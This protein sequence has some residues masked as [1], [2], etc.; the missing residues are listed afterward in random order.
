[1][2]F[3]EGLGY[4]L[5]MVLFIGPVF[6]TLL[7]GALQHGASGGVMVALGIITSDLIIAVI[8]ISGLVHLIERWLTGPWMALAGAVLLFALGLRYILRPKLD[9]DGPQR[10]KRRKAAGLF[11]RGFLVN[12]VNPFVFAIWI[13]LIVHATNTYGAGQGVWMFTTGVLL[14]IFLTDVGKALLAPRLHR[15]LSVNRLKKV[16]TVIGVFMIL[17]AVR[18]LFHAFANWD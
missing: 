9:M 16:Y 18:F 10:A 17:F 7:R 14:G 11:I 5:A 15:V 2:S 3:F 8:C 6:F 1:M 13:G 4:G 12:F